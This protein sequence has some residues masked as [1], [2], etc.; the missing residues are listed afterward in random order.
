MRVTF[1]ACAS[2]AS[3]MYPALSHPR[4]HTTLSF[5]PAIN[6]PFFLQ[7]HLSQALLV[8]LSFLSAIRFALRFHLLLPFLPSHSPKTPQNK[9]RKEPTFTRNISSNNPP[10]TQPNPRNL[11]L[12]RVRLLRLSNANSDTHTLHLRTIFQLRRRRFA[13]SL[14][15]AAAA[16]DL[17]VCCV[18]GARC[19][20]AAL[21]GSLALAQSGGEG[22]ERFGGK[23][24]VAEEG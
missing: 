2:V 7:S 10:I 5:R 13:G 20:E 3:P 14:G 18:L 12:S 4:L 21:E 16:E 1:S 24:E 9:K 11:P 8:F 6:I 17:V 22:C 19:A 15:D 23:A